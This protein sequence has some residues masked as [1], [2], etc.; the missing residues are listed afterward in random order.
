MLDAVRERLL[1]IGQQARGE[2][3]NRS[4]QDESC[5]TLSHGAALPQRNRQQDVFPCAAHETVQRS[6]DVRVNVAQ[7]KLAWQNA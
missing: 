1:K 4:Q 3:R 2:A 5:L 7:I 6:N